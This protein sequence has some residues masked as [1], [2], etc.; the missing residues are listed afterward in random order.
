MADPKT[1]KAHNFGNKYTTQA[2]LALTE[3]GKSTSTEV[4]FIA[5]SGAPSGAYNLTSAVGF[6]FRNDGSTGDLIMYWTVDTGAT[7]TA[8]VLAS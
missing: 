3:D 4:M 5:G 6:Y 2:G 1:K 8:A 7:W